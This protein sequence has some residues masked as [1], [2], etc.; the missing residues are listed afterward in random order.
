MT[1]KAITKM[2]PAPKPRLKGIN[3]ESPITPL[4]SK[5]PKKRIADL[6]VS[7]PF[8]LFAFKHQGYY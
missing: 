5:N 3:S 2:L 7:P 6:I 4:K 1:T 8:I